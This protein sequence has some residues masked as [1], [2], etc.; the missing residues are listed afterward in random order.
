MAR[1][2]DL[3]ARVSIEGDGPPVLL[4]MGLGGSAPMWEPVRA[5]LADFTTIAF[6]APG[7]G[8]S[9]PPRRPLSMLDHANLARRALQVAGVDRAAVIG[10]SFGGAVAQQLALL[11]PRP[12]R[13][14]AVRPQPA[15]HVLDR[16]LLRDEFFVDFDQLDDFGAHAGRSLDGATLPNRRNTG[17]GG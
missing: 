2:G 17:K 7:T 13:V 3:R 1:A 16:R 10:Y 9:P 11:D 6:D 15:R 5:R 4:V 14:E 12:D 8:G